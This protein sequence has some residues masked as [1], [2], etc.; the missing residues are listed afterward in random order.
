MREWARDALDQESSRIAPQVRIDALDSPMSSRLRDP[1]REIPSV[2]M[3]AIRAV[4][5]V[6]NMRT[7]MT[8]KYHVHHEHE[9]TVMT[10]TVI[11]AGMGLVL[12][13]LGCWE[14][15]KSIGVIEIVGGVLLFPMAFGLWRAQEWARIG[16]GC[17]SWAG[18]AALG[19][20]AWRDGATSFRAADLQGYLVRFGP[21]L[22]QAVF[23]ML[24][25][26]KRTFA[27]A[28]EAKERERIARQGMRGSRLA[29]RR[30]TSTGASG[31]P[32]ART[33]PN[34]ND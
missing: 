9:R 30:S 20:Y 25:S 7:P 4:P 16:V 14:L 11:A 34:E 2:R 10:L 21:T 32:R 27:A 12:V 13:S 22:G 28:R 33:E 24:P 5:A 18:C 15:P 6:R 17:L 19:W 3:H 29:Y 26:T 1:R 8:S 31:S 23:L